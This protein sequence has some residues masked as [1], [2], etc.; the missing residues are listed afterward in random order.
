MSAMPGPRWL[1]GLAVL[2]CALAAHAHVVAGTKTLRGLVAEADLV[3]RARIIASSEGLESAPEQPGQARPWVEA[4]VLEVLKGELEAPRVRFAQHGHG[5]AGFTPGEETLLFLV[6][7]ARSREL[8]ALGR[9]GT[10]AWVSL[11]EHDEEYPLTPASRERLLG[12]TRAYAAAESA[13]SPAQRSAQLREATLSLLVSGDSRLAASAIRDLV[14][15]PALA[16]I[17][18]ED[19]PQLLPVLDDPNAS[20]GVRVALLLELERRGLVEAPPRW[21]RLLSS[22]APTRDRVT[23]IRAAGATGEPVVRVQL[24]ELLSDPDER[25]AGAAATALGAPD[26]AAAAAPLGA[27]LAHASPTVR[28]AAIRGLGRIAG[29]EARKVLQEA[30]DGHPDAATRRRAGAEL[31][32]RSATAKH[33]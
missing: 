6:D 16:L 19:L 1:A 18:A 12:V 11:Q 2:L 33:D 27:A 5:V 7:I 3:L 32:K 26:N 28:N 25:V 20:M 9:A 10:F 30:A 13:T 17:G 15:D 31:R 29:P 24:V 21:I 14:E 22:D 23:A 4:R 8:A